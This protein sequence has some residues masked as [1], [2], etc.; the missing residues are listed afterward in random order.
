MQAAVV[1]VAQTR[2]HTSPNLT[3]QPHSQCVRGET[4]NYT[5]LLWQDGAS[6][7]CNAE[8]PF[9]VNSCEDMLEVTVYGLHRSQH[10]T[11][12]VVAYN[13]RISLR[14][15]RVDVCECLV[16]YCVPN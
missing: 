15:K 2:T 9:L 11:A 1:V 16:G 4:Y 10:Y 7:P 13:D 6:Q 5:V 8:G 14:S 3:V 12:V